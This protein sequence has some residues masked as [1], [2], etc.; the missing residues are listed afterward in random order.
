MPRRPVLYA[1]YYPAVMRAVELLRP[2]DPAAAAARRTARDRRLRQPGRPLCASGSRRPGPSRLLR[3]GR[4]GHPAAA[5]AHRRLPRRAVATPVRMPRRS[6]TTSGSIAY[7]LPFHG[8]S[9]PPVGP[10][11]WASEYRLD[12]GFLR[13]VPVSL[14]A[15]L[16]LAR[17]VFM[18]CSVGGLLALDLARRHGDLFRAVISLEGALKS[19]ATS[20][21]LSG[22]WHPQ[23]SNEYKARAM[24]ALMSPT[25]PEALSQGDQPCLRGGL[26]ARVPRRP[27]LLPGRLRPARDRRRNRHR[28]SRRAHPFR[29]VRLQR[30][31]GIRPGGACGHPG[32]DLDSDAGVGHF[33]MSE[34]PEAF[35]GYLLPVLATIRGVEETSLHFRLTWLSTCLGPRPPTTPYRRA[36]RMNHARSAAIVGPI[37]ASPLISTR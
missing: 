17:P 5:A 30:H 8:K 23:V 10:K 27:V 31:D 24:N 7:D 28:Q 20:R 12:G 11:W 25:S 9:L 19:R 37:L 33:P 22:F 32:F 18:G 29:R 34:H 15:A 16:G 6:P 35:L 14:A 26:A 4:I 36:R 13:A 2:P 21:A 1:Q 3:G